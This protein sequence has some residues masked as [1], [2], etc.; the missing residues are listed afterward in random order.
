MQT[1]FLHPTLLVTL[2]DPLAIIGILSILFP[3]VLLGIAIATGLIDLS[4]YR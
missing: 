2:Q 4:V 1:G 3:F